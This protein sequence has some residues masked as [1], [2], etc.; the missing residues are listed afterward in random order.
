MSFDTVKNKEDANYS[1][2]CP[3]CDKVGFTE[4]NKSCYYQLVEHC[5]KHHLDEAF[6]VVIAHLKRLPDKG[7]KQ[8]INNYWGV[9]NKNIKDLKP[10]TQK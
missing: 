8:M 1:W 2:S 6:D 10:V 4:W 7:K 5:Q 3:H 9:F